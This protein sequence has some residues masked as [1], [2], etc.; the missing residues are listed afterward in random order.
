MGFGVWEGDGRGGMWVPASARKTGRERGDFMG[1]MLAGEGSWGNGRMSERKEGLNP[2]AR[3]LGGL[4]MIF[5][6][7]GMGPRIREDTGEG[8]G[9]FS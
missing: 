3:F 8:E 7:R 1:G 9:S 5:G 6:L 2:V 4:G